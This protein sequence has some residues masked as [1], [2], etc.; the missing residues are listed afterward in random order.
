[1]ADFLLFREAGAG[2]RKIAARLIM[3]GS[4]EV[5]VQKAE[6]TN[7]SGEELG[8]S[9]VPLFVNSGSLVPLGDEQLS[10]TTGAA[11]ALAD[12]PDGATVAYIQAD[13]D[14]R[15]RDSGGDPTASTGRRLLADNEQV[16]E[17]GDVL[18]AL[19]FVAVTTTATLDVGYYRVGQ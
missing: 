6:L 12:V 8:T 4:D 1:M 14:V 18:A 17:G 9:T 11:V 2:I 16:F 5:F 10:V 19:R 7:S 13:Q 15:Y 3:D